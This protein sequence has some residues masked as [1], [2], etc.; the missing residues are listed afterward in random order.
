MNIIWHTKFKWENLRLVNFNIC[1]IKDSRWLLKI[2]GIFA[3]LIPKEIS[4]RIL[5]SVNIYLCLTWRYKKGHSENQHR[6]SLA[7]NH[8]GKIQMQLL[9]NHTEKKSQ[10]R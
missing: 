8:F 10:E 2:V 7:G 5:Y 1:K 4:L 6:Y 3:V 9:Q